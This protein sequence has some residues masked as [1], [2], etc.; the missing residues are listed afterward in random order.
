MQKQ[1]EN[2]SEATIRGHSDRRAEL[3]S[4]KTPW[5]LLERF[6]LSSSKCFL[7]TMVEEACLL[8][9]WG[10]KELKEHAG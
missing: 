8:L 10:M 6:W 1:R 3:V 5:E 2:S 4:W 7:A 9:L